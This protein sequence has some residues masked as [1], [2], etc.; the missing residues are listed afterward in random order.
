[1][2]LGAWFNIL[3]SA[4]TSREGRWKELGWGVA[5]EALAEICLFLGRWFPNLLGVMFGC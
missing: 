5:V 1:M 2:T 4:L 3:F